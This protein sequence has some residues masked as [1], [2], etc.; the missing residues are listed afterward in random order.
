M[1]QH[2]TPLLEHLAEDDPGFLPMY[3][4]SV[5]T[6]M[7]DIAMRITR[8]DMGNIQLYDPASAALHIE[9]ERGFSQAFLSFFSSVKGRPYS[10]QFGFPKPKTGRRRRCDG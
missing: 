4:R 5:F 3:W 7:V 9:A 8:A 6:A 1:R 2:L 10:V